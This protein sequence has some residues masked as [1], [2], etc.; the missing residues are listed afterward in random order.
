MP[1]D[2]TL[3]GSQAN[4]MNEVVFL[5]VVAVYCARRSVSALRLAQTSVE[6]KMRRL[7]H[8]SFPRG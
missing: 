5:S 7:C 4:M 1:F 2:L 8:V 6:K 3:E